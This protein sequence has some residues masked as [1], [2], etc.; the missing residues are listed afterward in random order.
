MNLPTCL[1]QKLC[2]RCVVRSVRT[3]LLFDPQT[4]PRDGDGGEHGSPREP[5]QPGAFQQRRQHVLSQQIPFTAEVRVYVRSC[6]F[7]CVCV[8]LYQTSVSD[9]FPLPPLL[10]VRHDGYGQQYPSMPYGMHPSGMY[11]QQQVRESTA[12]VTVRWKKSRP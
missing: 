5:E 2:Q 9:I 1:Q 7:V 10:Y 11:P 6:M 8:K 3:S 4:G 12:P